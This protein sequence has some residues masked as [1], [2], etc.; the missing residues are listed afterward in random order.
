[1]SWLYDVQLIL[2]NEIEVEPHPLPAL[3]DSPAEESTVRL[4][5][6]PWL[7]VNRVSMVISTPLA[8]DVDGAPLPVV[9]ATA[10][11]VG[12]TFVLT[13]LKL[14]VLTV[15]LVDPTVRMIRRGDPKGVNKKTA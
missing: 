13:T 9:P 14:T 11:G 12:A 6:L 8:G 1:M 5:V 7:L 10:T 3:Q 2:L 4:T 15:V